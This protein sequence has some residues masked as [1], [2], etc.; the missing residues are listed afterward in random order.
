MEPKT[1]VLQACIDDDDGDESYFRVLIN[2]VAIKYITIPPGIFS[3]D[4]M[5]FSPVLMTLLPPFP[6]GDWNDA[7]VSQ[8]PQSGLPYYKTLT[9]RAW[10]AITSTWHATTVDYLELDLGFKWK[11]AVYDTLLNA[12]TDSIVKFA[13]FDWEIEAVD[14]ETSVYQWIEGQAIGPAFQGHVTE[15]GRVIG[16]LIEKVAHA[17]HAGPEDLGL[18]EGVLAKLHRL[19]IKHGDVNRYNFLIH[20]GRATLIDFECARR[21]EDQDKL[22]RERQSLLEQLSETSGRGGRILLAG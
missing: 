12:S 4:D 21:C 9:K 19:G 10:P 22:E 8:D 7:Y 16:F 14:H 6:P 18:C 17:R 13:R 5:C 11:S 2:G 3:V 1:R 15:H 20:E